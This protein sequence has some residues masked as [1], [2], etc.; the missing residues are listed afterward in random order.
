MS[1]SVVVSDVEEKG[2]EAFPAWEITPPLLPRPFNVPAE[3]DPRLWAWRKGMDALSALSHEQSADAVVLAADTVVVAP[4]EL[5][6]KPSNKEDAF[7]MLNLLRGRDHYVVTGFVLLRL[8]DGK[9]QISHVRAVTTSVVMHDFSQEELKGYV[10]TGEC[11]DKAGAYALQGLGA[12]LVERVEGCV[13]NVIGLP[14]CAVRSVLV[15]AGPE[16]LPAPVTG[17]CDH[18]TRH[19]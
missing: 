16:V 17:Y 7:R 5:L 10:A 3:S 4:Y 14:L 18:C 15:E 19:R 13:T 2:S 11:M 9:P 6:G 1:H 8:T 12:R